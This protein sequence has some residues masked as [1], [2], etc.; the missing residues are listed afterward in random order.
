M[1]YNYQQVYN[2]ASTEINTSVILRLPDQAWIPNDSENS[3]WQ[4]YQ[5]WLLDGNQPLPPAGAK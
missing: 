1:E 2:T 3:D 5:V 4:A